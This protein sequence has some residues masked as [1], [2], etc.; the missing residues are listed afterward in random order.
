MKLRPTEVPIFG[1]AQ[2]GTPLMQAAQSIGIDL[3]LQALAWEDSEGQTWLGYNDP[4]RLMA[5]HGIEA[6]GATGTAAMRSM[7][8]AVTGRA[9]MP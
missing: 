9:A 5:G 1:S 6:A 7:L 4:V 3:P 8:A 2:G